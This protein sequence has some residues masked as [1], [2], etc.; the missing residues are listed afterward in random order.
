MPF[1]SLSPSRR[2]DV[3]KNIKE[4]CETISHKNKKELEALCTLVQNE[5]DDFVNNPLKL[6]KQHAEDNISYD[7]NP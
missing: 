6:C 5:R 2:E 4:L 7:L 3:M 1:P